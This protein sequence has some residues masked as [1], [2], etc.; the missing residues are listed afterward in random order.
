[1][2]KATITTI[3]DKLLKIYYVAK[4]WLDA[5]HVLS[6]LSLRQTH[7]FT[8]LLFPRVTDEMEAQKGYTAQDHTARRWHLPDSRVTA[9]TVILSLLGPGDPVCRWE[10]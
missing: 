6:Y 7:K 2:R 1:M 5:I 3:A 9:F 10:N 4:L 8:R